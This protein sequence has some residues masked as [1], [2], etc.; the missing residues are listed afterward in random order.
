MACLFAIFTPG[1]V[2]LLIVGAV[3]LLLFGHRLPGTMRSLGKGIT[4]FKKGLKED[5]DENPQLE[6][7]DAPS[8]A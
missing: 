5:D 6:D 3:I 1:P 4:E 7:K 8:E 2:Q